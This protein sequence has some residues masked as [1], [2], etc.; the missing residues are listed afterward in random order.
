MAILSLEQRRQ[1]ERADEQANKI[2]QELAEYDLA[3]SRDPIDRRRAEKQA[4]QK[5]LEAREAE[6]NQRTESWM[7]KVDHRIGQWFTYY[8]GCEGYDKFGVYNASMGQ[9]LAENR[10]RAEAEVK[11]IYA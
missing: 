10:K 1:R 3:H 2:R 7:A 6:Q 9:V 11:K 4:E 5:A 8:F